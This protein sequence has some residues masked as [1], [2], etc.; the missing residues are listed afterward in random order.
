MTSSD[1]HIEIATL[2]ARQGPS[3]D[4]QA[5]VFILGIMPRSGTNFLHRLLCQHPDCGAIN[6]TP[7]REDYLIHHSNWLGRYL[8]RLKWQ[9]GHWGADDAFVTPLAHH[10]GHGL[11]NFLH[12]L[13]DAKR[14]VTKTPSVANLD[15]FFAY[16]PHAQLIVIVRDGRSVVASGMSG[17]G[18]N[19]ETATRQWAR[20]ARVIVNFRKNNPDFADRVKIVQYEQLNA[21]TADELTEVLKF[22]NLDVDQ[23]DF[24]AALNTP[25]YGSSFMKE[26]GDQ[27]TWKPQEKNKDFNAGARWSKWKASR[28]NR[29][30]WIARTELESLGYEA[31]GK[32]TFGAGQ[33]LLHGT[34]DLAYH[35]RRFPGRLIRAIRAGLRAFRRDMQG[36]GQANLNLKK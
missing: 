15:A 20:S 5:P 32:K 10:V 30:N 26:K 11:T 19:F 16:F 31:A 24:D 28:H 18:W 13:T 29:F 23:F 21:E 22:L 35:A 7:V 25:V 6:T 17:F 12:S 36:K 9:W 33:R 2:E 14:F 8:G 4:T 1:H 27:V 3:V 34:L